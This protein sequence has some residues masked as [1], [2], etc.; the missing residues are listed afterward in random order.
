MLR[1]AAI[2]RIQDDL[3]FANRQ[4]DKI[5]NRLQ[6][7]QRILEAGTSLPRFLVQEAQTLA[8]AAGDSTIA[9]PAGFLRFDDEFKPYF[10]DVTTSRPHFL[11]VVRS[12]SDAYQANITGDA[13]A[14][15]VMVILK[16]TISFI[17]PLNEARTIYWQYFKAA[18]VLA[19]DIENEWLADT[20]G[21]ADWL[22]GEAGWRMAMSVRDKEAVTIFDNLRKTGRAAC[23]GE[24]VAQEESSGPLVMGA[25]L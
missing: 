10:L 18:Q 6:E 14:P 7:A 22:I 24:I 17:N 5:V 2:T 20:R 13:E 1:S 12:Y 3:G 15:A 8:L 11:R 21:G 19:T 9:R 25:N 4:S 16:S 23:F